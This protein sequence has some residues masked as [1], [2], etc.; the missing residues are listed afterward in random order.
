MDMKE[1][2]DTSCLNATIEVDETTKCVSVPFPM[3]DDPK[4]LGIISS[5][6]GKHIDSSTMLKLL[7]PIMKEARQNRL[8]AL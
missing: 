1:I 3:Y 5:Y 8:A 7:A 2:Q 4:V 6:H